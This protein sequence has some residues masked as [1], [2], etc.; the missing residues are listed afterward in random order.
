LFY[1]FPEEGKTEARLN[2]SFYRL[3]DMHNDNER[4]QNAKRKEKIKKKRKGKIR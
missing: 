3:T 2:K 1:P 4:K